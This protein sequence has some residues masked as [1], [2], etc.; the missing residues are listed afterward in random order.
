MLN[1]YTDFQHELKRLKDFCLKT[2]IKRFFTQKCI[3]NKKYFLRQQLKKFRIF[4]FRNIKLFYVKIRN[5]IK[6][7]DQIT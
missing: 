1:F 3:L 6:N 4:Q 7:S 2:A 5:L